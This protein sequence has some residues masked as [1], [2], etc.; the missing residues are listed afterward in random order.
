M[1]E[2]QKAR[3][4]NCDLSQK[5]LVRPDEKNPLTPD[6]V[7]VG[8]QGEI[9]PHLTRENCKKYQPAGDNR[10]DSLINAITIKKRFLRFWT[11]QIPVVT[12]SVHSC[13]ACKNHVVSKKE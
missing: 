12:C 7:F 9:I 2:E 1:N 8:K 13:Q 6:T 11:R 10:Q 5:F 3:V 4:V